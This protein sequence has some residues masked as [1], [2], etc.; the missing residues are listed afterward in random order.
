MADASGSRVSLAGLG[1]LTGTATTAVVAGL[2]SVDVAGYVVAAQ[3][4][5]GV[6]IA[7]GDVVLISRQGPVWWVVGRAYTAAPAPP[8][9]TDPSPP[10]Q[11]AT[12]EGVLVCQA[13]STGSYRGGKWRTDTDDVLQG[14]YAGYPT[15]TGAAFYGDKPRSLAGATVTSARLTCHRIRGGGFAPVAA[16]LRLVTQSVRPAGAPTLTSSTTVPSLA[17]GTSTSTF[18]VPTAWVQD[19]VDGTAGGLGVSAATT[20]YI[21][22]RGRSTAAAA[23]TLAIGWSR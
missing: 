22:F 2:V 9:A 7:A 19:I 5:R 13:V 23:F 4:L 18:A 10:P 8:E 6:T 14:V 20:P 11:P 16:T 21:R 3:V 17:V 15:N 1:S 12:V